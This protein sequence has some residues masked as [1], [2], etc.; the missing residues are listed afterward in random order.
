MRLIAAA[1][2]LHQDSNTFYLSNYT[3]ALTLSTILE[4]KHNMHKTQHNTLGYS[5][6]YYRYYTSHN[7]IVS[8]ITLYI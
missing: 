3:G 6:F 5:I 8:M 2:T 7:S 4:D 1:A